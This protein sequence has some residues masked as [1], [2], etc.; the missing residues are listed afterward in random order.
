MEK[1]KNNSKRH[2]SLNNVP[3]RKKF[4]LVY[5]CIVLIA[6][7]AVAVHLITNLKRNAME[8]SIESSMK[9]AVQI[10]NQYGSL[11]D[12]ALRVSD[13]ISLDED[14]RRILRTGYSSHAEAYKDYEKFKTIQEIMNVNSSVVQSVC[15]YTFNTTLLNGAYIK[16]L[17]KQ[18]DEAWYKEFAEDDSEIKWILYKNTSGA[19]QRDEITLLRKIYYSGQMIGVMKIAINMSNMNEMLLNQ[20]YNS[21]IVD[22][23]GK[24]IA[25]QEKGMVGNTFSQYSSDFKGKQDASLY[26]GKFGEKA[27]EFFM[28]DLSVRG[29]NGKYKIISVFLIED[30][31]KEANQLTVSSVIIVL[32]ILLLDMVIIYVVSRLLS[33][34]LE[35]LSG[36]ISRVASGDLCGCVSVDGS[37][38]I[39]RLGSNVNLMIKNLNRLVQEIYYMNEE[40]KKLITKQREIQFKML[41]SQINPHFIFNTLETIRMHAHCR[42]EEAI[43]DVIQRFGAIMRN[44]LSKVDEVVPLKVELVSIENY[45]YI[46]KYRFGDRLNYQIIKEGELENI[47]IL[48]LLLQPLVENSVIHGIENKEENGT[49]LLFLELHGGMLYIKVQDDGVGM[50]EEKLELLKKD[51][52]DDSRH[53]L[54][55]IG[56]KNVHQRL[57]IYYGAKYGLVIESRRN[58][59]TCISFCIPV[60]SKAEENIKT[61]V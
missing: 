32:I 61:A 38:E 21:M 25:A 14:L 52:A 49:I 8:S 26:T 44:N 24:I 33:K 1:T 37:D 23:Y 28:E 58:T 19:R 53:E 9:S 2:F 55:H 45:L 43:A 13:Q 18:E 36:E 51:I 5:G 47:Q 57:C 27:A 50:E 22:N 6:V 54:T 30:I 46:Q 4:V 40:E 42:G 34:R 17:S 11:L 48:P 39:G 16:I 59:G 12:T 15:V 29:V 20:T 7:S 60:G 35:N 31:Y 56:V 10:K 41:V 3:I